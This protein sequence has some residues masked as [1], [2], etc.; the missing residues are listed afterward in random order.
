MRIKSSYNDYKK[1][2]TTV[3]YCYML[4]ITVRK[5]GKNEYYY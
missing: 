4:N 2:L 5:G 3:I 1:I